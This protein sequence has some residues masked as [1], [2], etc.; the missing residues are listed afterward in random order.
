MP[1]KKSKSKARAQ[2]EIPESPER[3]YSATPPTVYDRESSPETTKSPHMPRNGL[4]AG[5]GMPETEISGVPESLRARRDSSVSTEGPPSP[6]YAS[7]A[8]EGGVSLAG[9]LPLLDDQQPDPP[10]WLQTIEAQ[11]PTLEHTG[12]A[13]ATPVPWSGG[14]DGTPP[15]EEQE[16]PTISIK[17]KLA[18][19]FYEPVLLMHLL[20]QIRGA[21]TKRPIDTG[22]FRHSRQE[23]RRDF[24]DAIAYICAFDTGGGHVMAAALEQTP[25]GITVWLAANSTRAGENVIAFLRDIL[26]K[27]VDIDTQN[28]VSQIETE[29]WIFRKIVRFNRRRIDNY[30]DRAE[31][32]IRPCLEV[33]RESKEFKGRDELIRWLEVELVDC[34]ETAESLVRECYNA[35]RGGVHGEQFT[36]IERFIGDGK[37]K[38]ESFEKLRYYICRLGKHLAITKRMVKT[39]TTD[40]A[41]FSGFEIKLLNSPGPELYKLLPKNSTIEGIFNRMFSNSAERDALLRPL[42]PLSDALG[43]PEQLK[44]NCQ[45]KTRVHAELLLVDHFHAKQLNFVDS[46]KYVGCSKPACF[47]CYE[48]ISAHPGGFALPATHNKLYR[49]WRHPDIIDDGP[50]EELDHLQKCRENIINEMVKKIRAQ[51]SEQLRGGI[52]QNQWRSHPDSSTGVSTRYLPYRPTPSL[53]GSVRID[54]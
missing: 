21:R 8:L 10:G 4:E 49:G 17:R 9:G 26:A 44:K 35:A 7:D 48:Y 16:Y 38:S 46:D 41:L 54:G 13:E 25:Q 11:P 37:T 18:R 12:G 20:S 23:R 47:L 50:K 5:S 43:L 6:I 33:I 22:D 40:R 31:L 53:L 42:R 29:S 52:G 45:F 24:A 39:S 30:W 28:E 36:A 32:R 27:L 2:P 51:L 19:R 14:V 1:K 3:R 15:P 34:S